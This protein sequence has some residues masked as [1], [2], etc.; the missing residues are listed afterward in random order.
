MTLLLAV[1]LAAVLP[2]GGAHPVL[3]GPPDPLPGYH[4]YDALTA[5]LR[6]AV[7]GHSDIARMESIGKTLEGRDIW[8][9]EVG[10]RS[11]SPL[12]DRPALLVV[13]NLDGDQLVGSEIALDMVEYLIAGYAG[14]D[15]IRARLDETVFY[16]IPRA[17]PDGAERM[18]ASLQTGQATNTSST[19][20]DND[21]RADE[22][23]PDDLNGDG[24][25]TMMRVPDA[26]GAYASES[27]DERLLKVAAA[28][29]GETGAFK[30]Y[31]EGLDDDGDGF[32]NEDPAGGVDI[33]RNFQHNYPYYKVGSGPHMVSELESR[34]I[35]DFV[36]AH[37]NIAAVY[38]LGPHDNLV[39]PPN[40]KGE[41][42][43]A[44]SVML[45]DFADGSNTDARTT[46]I[47][48]A[49]RR[50]GF[51]RGGGGQQARTGR[52]S[53]GRRPET[54]VNKDD[55]AYFKKVSDAYREIVGLTEL[56]G[57]DKPEGALFEYGY[58]QFGVP[59]FSSPGWAPEMAQAA[60]SAAENGSGGRAGRGGGGN[61]G[62]GN[63]GGGDGADARILKWMDSVGIDGFLNW[64][65]FQ[66]PTL[67]A[68]EIGG[69][70]PYMYSNPPRDMLAELAPKHGAFVVELAGL[71]AKVRIASTQV[72]DHGGGVFRIKAEVE[73]AGFFPTSTA[74][75]VASR[76][77]RPTMV[78]LEIEPDALLSGDAKTSFF[79]AM[80]GSGKRD[81]FEWIVSGRRGDTVTLRVV[82]QKGGQDSANITLR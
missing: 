31:W 63:G 62:G 23:G 14:D 43:P 22:D 72:T 26:M 36:V 16:V 7:Q 47:F 5:A 46:G 56:P 51:F 73:N 53:S 45:P 25:I 66:H 61:G 12:A 74:H 57:T 27:D 55:Q 29:K 69:F 48:E 68:V 28:S 20:D 64:T 38:V 35:M 40:N 32:Y 37:R 59:S 39:N 58:Y 30:V 70:K 21:G 52:P 76:S 42:S 4:N 34:A 41:L 9:V 78:Q 50:G 49:P 1:L 44:S 82:S 18:F 11:G 19:D 15:D 13:A 54:T 6:S 71:F 67:G 3:T 60:D 79:Q 80:D 10:S 8:M 81:S 24:M 77:V 65:P 2:T 33:N 75:G 17:S